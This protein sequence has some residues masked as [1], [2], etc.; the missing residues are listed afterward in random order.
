[1]S[2]PF[3]LV[4]ASRRPLAVLAGG[5][6]ALM[7]AGPAPAPARAAPPI[8]PRGEAFGCTP[9]M[10]WDGDGPVWCS[11]GPRLRL[12]GIAAREM[13]GS[14]RRGQPCPGATAVQARDALVK[15]LG[16]AT[17]TARDGHIQVRGPVLACRSDGPAG[18]SRTAAWCTSGAT[19]DLSC[20]MVRTGTVLRWDRFWRN[21]RC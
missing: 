9:T 14:C 12:S 8:V 7:L 21:H 19:G 16:G 15:L 3:R 18:G 17:G 1:M 10:V 13:D 11:E 5:V 6:F 20:A 4:E 2:P